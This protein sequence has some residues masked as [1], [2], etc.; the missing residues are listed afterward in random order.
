MGHY[1]TVRSL[2]CPRPERKRVDQRSQ[3]IFQYNY[4]VARLW[5]YSY[6]WAG[7]ASFMGCQDFVCLLRS[8]R[9]SQSQLF[10]T[11]LKSK[12]KI[13]AASKNVSAIVSKRNKS[14]SNLIKSDKNSIYQFFFCPR[15]VCTAFCAEEQ[16]EFFSSLSLFY[17][18]V[19]WFKLMVKWWCWYVISYAAT[20]MFACRP[21]APYCFLCL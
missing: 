5:V 19:L 15:K 6:V 1:C 7:P 18:V 11:P 12:S 20:I 3:K 4:Y 16:T 9:F 2:Y 10:A 14:T 21:C 17:Y 13:L 8:L